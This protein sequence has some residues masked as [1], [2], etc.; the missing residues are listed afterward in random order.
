ML[1]SS[2]TT[3]KNHVL[4][5]LLNYAIAIFR[6]SVSG[7][8]LRYV[9]YVVKFL[10]IN[11]AKHQSNI[12]NIHV[13]CTVADQFQAVHEL[14]PNLCPPYDIFTYPQFYM[15]VWMQRTQCSVMQN[16]R[17]AWTLATQS[18]WTLS[19]QPVAFSVS[20]S[21]TPTWIS[22][23]IKG[24]SRNQDAAKTISPVSLFGLT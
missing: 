4:K 21:L 1:I 2:K 7:Y 16:R 20:K 3:K 22:I 6:Y 17:D 5:I 10:N 11:C 15:Q 13:A 24:L 18:W 12:E 8:W 19:T 23:L 9:L 14:S